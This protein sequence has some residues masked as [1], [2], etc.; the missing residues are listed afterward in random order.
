MPRGTLLNRE[1]TILAE[2]KGT[3]HAQMSGVEGPGGGASFRIGCGRYH[4]LD[5]EKPA[6]T[7]DSRLIVTSHL[8]RRN[9]LRGFL[10]GT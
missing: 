10:D 6:A 3:G 4:P 7:R 2:R 5:G 8:S 9:V 1:V